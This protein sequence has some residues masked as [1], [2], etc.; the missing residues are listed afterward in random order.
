MEP[1]APPRLSTTTDLPRI[2]LIF[3]AS[4]RATISVEPPAPNGTTRRIGRLG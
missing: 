4:R 3:S 2:T 1:P